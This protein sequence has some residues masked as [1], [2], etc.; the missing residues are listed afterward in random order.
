MAILSDI[1]KQPI[2]FKHLFQLIETFFENYSKSRAI[3]ITIRELNK[4]SDRD[5]ADLGM[6][7]SEIISRAK[8]AGDRR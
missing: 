1:P 7:R 4:L 8:N 2:F 5:L 6:S 3:S